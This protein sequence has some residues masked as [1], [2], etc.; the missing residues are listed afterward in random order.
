VHVVPGLEYQ[1]T[2][3]QPCGL[4]P[5]VAGSGTPVVGTPIGRHQLWG[6][7]ACLDPLAWLRA[8]P[9]RDLQKPHA[10]DARAV[11]RDVPDRSADDESATTTLRRALTDADHLAALHA[12]WQSETAGPRRERYRSCIA[13]ALPAGRDPAE[14][15]T[16]Q[17]T[18]LWRT[19][20]AAETAGHDIT[21]VVQRAGG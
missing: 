14:L 9:A 13:T 18:W 2:T 1:A 20:R 19:L 21:E 3:T 15:D 10:R 4:Y 5:F 11:L 8:G 12:I 17:A 16:P 6:E 7:V